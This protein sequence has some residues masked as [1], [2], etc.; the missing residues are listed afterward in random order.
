MRSSLFIAE[1]SA[2]ARWGFDAKL[3]CIAKKSH[4]DEWLFLTRL[5]RI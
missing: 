3:C 2:S 5:R 1:L 4:S